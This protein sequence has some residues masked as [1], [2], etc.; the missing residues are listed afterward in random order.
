MVQYKKRIAEQQKILINCSN[1]NDYKDRIEEEKNTLVEGNGSDE[2]STE[3]GRSESEE[4]DNFFPPNIQYT[5]VH[6]KKANSGH[7]NARVTNL[8]RL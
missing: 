4:V 7:I 6:S 2:R 5:V 3:E 1:Y 8:L